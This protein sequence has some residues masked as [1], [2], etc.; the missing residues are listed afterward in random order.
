MTANG[1]DTLPPETLEAIPVCIIDADPTFAQ[2]L[3]KILTDRLGEQVYIVG[4]F[5][6]RPE[7]AQLADHLPD[8]VIFDPDAL[9]SRRK[10]D[11]K[12]RELAEEVM[13]LHELFGANVVLVAHTDLWKERLN[14]LRLELVCSGVVLGFK[15]Y[16]IKAAIEL[17]SGLS[18]RLPVQTLQLLFGI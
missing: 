11:K 9:T 6:E 17:I 13:R 14:P 12:A 4:V 1:S 18:S 3:G 15:R 5:E 10:D 2:Q 7:L 16:D 8:V